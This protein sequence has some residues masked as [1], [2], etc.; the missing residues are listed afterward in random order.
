MSSTFLEEAPTC[1]GPGRTLDLHLAA[2]GLCIVPSSTSSMV[3]I[4][5][6][7]WRPEGGATLA[8]ARTAS[9]QYARASSSAELTD[10]LALSPG[11]LFPLARFCYSLMEYFCDRRPMA[12]RPIC[13]RVDLLIMI[14]KARDSWCDDAPNALALGCDARRVAP[15]CTAPSDRGDNTVEN[16][17][18]RSRPREG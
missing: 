11:L 2:R 15:T 1:L 16:R 5:R 3:G 7:G 12:A 17:R 8:G 4:T 10:Q 13:R 14:S 6:E 9:A 18:R